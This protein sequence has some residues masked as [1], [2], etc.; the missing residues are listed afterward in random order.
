PDSDGFL[1]EIEELRK[2]S[3]EIPNDY[4][5]YLVGDMITEEALL[6]Y[7]TMLNGRQMQ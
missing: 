4:F 7:Q 3:R 2:R 5:V 1:E 6:T